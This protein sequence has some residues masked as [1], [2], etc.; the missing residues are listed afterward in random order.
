[1]PST[2]GKKPSGKLVWR[3]LLAMLVLGAIAAYG[4]IDRDHSDAKLAEWTQ[5]QA[6]PSVDL[7]TPKHPT[8][9]QHL[10]LPSDIEA[11][12]TAP[13]HARVNGYVKMWYYDIGAKVKAGTIL[14]KIDTPDLDQQYEQAVGE[15]NKAQADYNLAVQTADRWKALRASQ[16]VSQQTADE[17]SGDALA[18]KAQVD[19]AKANVDRIKA[20]QSFKD[21]TAPFDGVVTARRIDVGA[22]VSST[23]NNQPGL[24]DVAAIDQM[25]VYVRVPQIYTASLKPGMVVMLKLPQF[26]GRTFK[27]KLTTTSDAIS[28]ESRAQLVELMA[29]NSDEQLFPGA[30]AQA[31][32]DLPL[33]PDKMVIPSSAVVFRNKMPEVAVVDERNVVHLKPISI[34][35]DTGTEIQIASGLAVTD[36]LIASPSDSVADGDEVR[37]SEIDGKPAGKLG[38]Q[39]SR[40]VTE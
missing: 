17:K 12:Y 23:N 6:I 19:A 34:L 24:F 3:L 32:F 36:R 1:M 33:D 10:V 15:F 13:I 35:V 25:R 16:A 40:S 5:A 37:I 2:G 4:I 29:D 21:I 31:T 27:A 20:L 22:L 28:S 26:P 11:F 8:E 18:K 14:A 9:I 39:A 38:A 7:V 30:Y